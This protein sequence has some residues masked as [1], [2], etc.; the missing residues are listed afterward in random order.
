VRDRH[1]VELHA[2][3]DGSFDSR[4]STRDFL[5]RAIA[6]GLTHVAITDHGTI[7]RAVEAMA[8]RDERINVIVGQ[9]IRTSDGDLIALFLTEAVPEGLSVAETS[10]LVRQQGGVVG[11]PH[12]FDA[13][14]PSIGVALDHPKELLGL[15]TLVDYVEIHNGRVR[16]ARA[17][18]RAAEFANRFELPGVAAS[19]SHTSAE[20]AAATNSWAV[21][22]IDRESFLTALRTEPRLVVQAEAAPEPGRASVMDRIRRRR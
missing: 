19:D 12:G 16:D 7:A 3:T 10:R 8:N 14:R 21:G 18:E 2:H 6:M 5:D 13:Y 1:R 9:E 20:V 22:P 15:S 17:N 4:L 11:L